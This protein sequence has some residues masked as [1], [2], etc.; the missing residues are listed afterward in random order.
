M[1]APGGRQ[2]SA[3]ADGRE[4]DRRRDGWRVPG[5]GITSPVV[6]VEQ[7]VTGR[8]VEQGDHIVHQALALPHA[9]HAV[10]RRGGSVLE[11][12]GGSSSGGL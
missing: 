4:P 12:P 5:R 11:D 7:G 9:Q 8:V 3:G 1:V 2:E 10:E 6:R